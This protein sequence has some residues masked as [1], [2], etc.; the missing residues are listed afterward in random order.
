M[1][2]QVGTY[3]AR[4]GCCTSQPKRP[5]NST[6][7]NAPTTGRTTPVA[8]HNGRTASRRVATEWAAQPDRAAGTTYEN[9]HA[10][11]TTQSV[12][13]T[14]RLPRWLGHHVG[15]DGR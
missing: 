7:S 14:P 4:I 11:T 8:V 10:T 1:I 13:P 6:A 9:A 5:A 12:W 3:R 2:Q 15:R